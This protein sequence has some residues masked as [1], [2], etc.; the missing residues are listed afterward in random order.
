VFGSHVTYVP[1]ATGISLW[2]VH[3]TKVWSDL[4]WNIVAKY[5]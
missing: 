2:Y 1:K 3:Y 4:T 5:G